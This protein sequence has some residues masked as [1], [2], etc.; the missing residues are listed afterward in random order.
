M[1]SRLTAGFAA[2]LL[3]SVVPGMAAQPA[4]VSRYDAYFGYALLDSPN[5]GLV[6]H[7]FALQTGVRVNRWLSAGFDYSFSTGDLTLTPGL[8]TTTLQQQL[9]AQLGQLAAL[10]ALPPGYSLAVPAH[11]RTQTFAV[12]PQVS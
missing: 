8:L 2:A 5:V 7:G 1:L 3:F 12:G 9:A 6:E 10:G 11:S 4:Y